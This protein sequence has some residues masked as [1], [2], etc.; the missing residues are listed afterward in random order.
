MRKELF[1]FNVPGEINTTVILAH[2]ISH[3]EEIANRVT[4][5]VP[6]RHFHPS[7]LKE[8]EKL[9]ISHYK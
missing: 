3:A 1:S 2:G 8:G 7:D 9:R 5:G 4:K 6:V